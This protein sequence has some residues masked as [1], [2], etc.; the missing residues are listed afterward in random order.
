MSGADSNMTHMEVGSSS[1]H[2]D[3][4]GT[5]D[6][7]GQTSLGTPIDRNLLATAGGV[8]TDNKIVY[9]CTWLA[10]DGSGGITE[11]GIFNDDTVGTMLARTVFPIVNKGDDDSMTI[12]WTITVS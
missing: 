2:P 5:N 3:D 7:S 12:T 6:A 8:V 11:A 9:E 10:E 4:S 1:I